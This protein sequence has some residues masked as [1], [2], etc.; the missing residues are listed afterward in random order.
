MAV[1]APQGVRH[2]TRLT[3]RS[4]GI[5]HVN[6]SGLTCVSPRRRA[7]CVV[8]VQALQMGARLVHRPER[9]RVIAPAE[10]AIDLHARPVAGR[11]DRDV[12]HAAAADPPLAGDRSPRARVERFNRHAASLPLV[13][14]GVSRPVLLKAR[15]DGT[16]TSMARW[17]HRRT[18]TSARYLADDRSALHSGR[19][20][21]DGS[22]GLFGR[23]NQREPPGG[24]A[25]ARAAAPC[26]RSSPSGRRRS[27]RSSASPAP[28]PSTTTESPASTAATRS[29]TRPSSR[30]SSRSGSAS[31]RGYGNCPRYLRGV[32]V[33]PTEELEALRRPLPPVRPPARRH[34]PHHAA[35]PRRRVVAAA[36]GWPLLVGLVLLLAVGAGAGRIR[37]AP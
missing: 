16:A 5:H 25:R 36:D 23:R 17:Y 24:R 15:D 18:W 30:P 20:Q 8:A 19:S 14:R 4:P 3:G 27:A 6:G 12:T 10:Q 29:A 1:A 22:P 9:E 35:R 37:P 13:D 33:I 26:S 11:Q 2:R 31:E 34:R 21:R 32:L 28:R 7:R